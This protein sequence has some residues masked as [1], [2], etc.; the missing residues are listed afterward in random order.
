MLYFIFTLTIIIFIIVI[1]L[2]KKKKM[3]RD[4]DSEDVLMKDLKYLKAQLLSE[5]DPN[6]RKQ[7]MKKIELI[8]SHYN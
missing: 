4:I 8:Y 1:Y 2:K 6:I 7:I 5:T 3:M